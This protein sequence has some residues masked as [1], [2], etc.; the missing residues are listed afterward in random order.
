MAGKI[1]FKPKIDKIIETILYLS[2]KG[3]RLD[4][5]KIVKLIYLADKEHL[6]RYGRPITFDRIVAMENG[7]VASK[8]YDILKGRP[9]AGVDP[10]T[11]PFT[12]RKIDPLI[13]VEDPMREVNKHIFSKSDLRVL[14]EV[15]EQ[16]GDADF[17]TLYNLT[18]THFAYRKAWEAR[19]RKR[20]TDMF[21]E[22][23][24]EER[25][26]KEN[27]VEDLALIAP[28]I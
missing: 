28:H 21:F 9:V 2:H 6:N 11:L 3:I 23:L 10:A 5:Y 15:C 27:V 14:D 24:I 18:H 13:F 1:Q 26:E 4:Q 8:A 12:L 22:D 19:G 7:P 20:S 25:K 17:L 16:Y